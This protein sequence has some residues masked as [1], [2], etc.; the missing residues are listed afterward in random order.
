MFRVNKRAAVSH[1]LLF[2]QNRVAAPPTSTAERFVMVAMVATITMS[3]GRATLL[4]DEAKTR[5]MATGY[6]RT[7]DPC[8]W[9]SNPVFVHKRI[10]DVLSFICFLSSL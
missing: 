10:K 6:R 3:A 2:K 7:A 5:P 4:K 8:T 9:N 1:P